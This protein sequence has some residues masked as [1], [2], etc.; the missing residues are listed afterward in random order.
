MA[1]RN[2][3]L[4]C[5]SSGSQKRERTQ[6]QKPRCTCPQDSAQEFI[7]DNILFRVLIPAWDYSS[8]TS[9]SHSWPFL[10]QRV[11]KCKARDLVP[12]HRQRCLI[13]LPGSLP[14][15]RPSGLRAQQGP[16]ESL[17]QRLCAHAYPTS[18]AE[19]YSGP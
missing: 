11:C 16:F 3:P 17:K 5:P 19:R 7:L 6:V 4:K 12:L 15:G 14:S 10:S 13:T 9:V 18:N 8:C 2:L 1:N